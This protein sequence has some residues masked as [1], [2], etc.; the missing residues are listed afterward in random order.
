[1]RSRPIA[2]IVA[3]LLVSSFAAACSSTGKTFVTTASPESIPA[4]KT[5]SLAVQSMTAEASA[6]K[7]LVPLQAELAARLVAD[8]IFKDVVEPPAASDYALNVTIT[9]ARD[10][11]GGRIAFG[12]FAPRNYLTVEVELRDRARDQV[13]ESFV[14]TGYGAR[15]WMT[16]QGYGMD[17]PVREVVDQVATALQ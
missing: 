14:T 2:K 8:R 16:A 11:T 9:E 4:G 7:T 1:M 15:S 12:F 5:V 6:Q 13:V 3:V 17:D 10:A